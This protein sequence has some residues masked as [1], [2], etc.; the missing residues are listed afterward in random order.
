MSLA[1]ILVLADSAF[2][3]GAFGHSFGL[4]TA[5]VEGRAVDADGVQ[6]WISA[7]LLDGLATLDAAALV[8]AARDNC[9]IRSL[10]ELVSAAIVADELRAANGQLARATLAAYEA[11]RLRSPGI[12]RY[13]IALENGEDRGI[14]S[15]ACGLG[16]AAA[17]VPWRDGL[18]A[19]LS[20]TASALV[21]VAVR[22][23]PLG[24]RA[25]LDT[26]WKLRPVIEEAARRAESI[27]SADD[28]RTQAF[29]CEIDAMRHAFLDGRMFVS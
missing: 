29:D 5:I 25:G 8:L 10:D 18:R 6:A 27:G 11:M 26:L 13:R 3:T 12:E 17:S 2:P 16:Y 4:E 1:Q 28:L 22:A 23:I 21:S 24:Q 14:H 19:Y 9:E 20:S 15:L 7:F